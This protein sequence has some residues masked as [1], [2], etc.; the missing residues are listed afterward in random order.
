M[1]MNLIFCEQFDFLE[2]F[3]FSWMVLIVGMSHV[4]LTTFREPFSPFL[5]FELLQLLTTLTTGVVE[6]I[7]DNCRVVQDN[8]QSHFDCL[9]CGMQYA[10][11]PV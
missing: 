2:W 4:I 10:L 1:K 11:W 6:A 9:R 7:L 5:H 3:G 8:L